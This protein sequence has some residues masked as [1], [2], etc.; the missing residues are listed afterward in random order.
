MSVCNRGSPRNSVVVSRGDPMRQTA[1]YAL[2]I[3]LASLSLASWGTEFPTADK[4]GSADHPLVSRYEG[5]KIVAYQVQSYDETWL[6][7]GPGD[8]SK[9]PPFMKVLNLEG[10]ITHIAYDFPANRSAL[11]VMRN[12]EMA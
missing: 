9:K 12:Y 10:K 7:A 1:F 8:N 3:T 2:L 6:A 4:P 5:A 11:E